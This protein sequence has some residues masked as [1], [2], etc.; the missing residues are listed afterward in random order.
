[1]PRKV[2]KRNGSYTVYDTKRISSAIERAALSVNEKVNIVQV[3]DKV[4]AQL[5]EIAFVETIQD[6]IEKTLFMEGY[7]ATA[8]AFIIYRNNT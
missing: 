1:M 4:T 7:Y 8:K 3:V 6:L 2:R 5:D